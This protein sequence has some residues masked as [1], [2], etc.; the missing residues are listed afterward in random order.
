[1]MTRPSG[2][3]AAGRA[4]MRGVHDQF[5]HLPLGG[6]RRVIRRSPAGPAARRVI[7]LMTTGSALA[8]GALA[9]WRTLAVLGPARRDAPR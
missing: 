9:G 8:V 3:F 5:P 2:A 4:E 6:G 7:E 1:M